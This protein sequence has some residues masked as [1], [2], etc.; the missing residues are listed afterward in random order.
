VPAETSTDDKA[1]ARYWQ[2]MARYSPT[3]VP[4]RIAVLRSAS[5]EDMRPNLGWSS[6]GEHV[7]THAIPG[8]H[9]SSIT[10]YVAE[11]AARM[12]A[13]ID[14]ALLPQPAEASRSPS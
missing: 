2:A 9:H 7:E 3:R 1:F 12:R 8:D 13:C 14:A 10:R 5:F 11:T 6:I 4:V